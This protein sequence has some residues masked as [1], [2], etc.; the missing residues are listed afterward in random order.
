MRTRTLHQVIVGAS[1]GDAIT[2]QALLVRSWLRDFG[3]NSEIYAE[4]IHEDLAGDIR[5]VASLRLFRGTP[6]LIVHHSIGSNILDELVR[7]DVRLILV[8]HNVTPPEFFEAI[9]PT[10]AYM[11]RRG[12]DQLL[13]LQQRTA[14]ALADS[15]YNERELL[16][17]GF[18]RTG[19]LP[20][21]L[22]ESLYN[23][24]PDVTMLQQL[25]N[26]GPRLLFVGR[27]A[28]NKK[29]EDLIKL[30]YFYRR[31]EPEAQLIL[32]G[33]PWLLGYDRWLVDLANSLGIGSA[34]HLTGRV[35]QP[36]LVTYYHAADL[37]VSMS[38]HE[39]FG[40]PLIESMFLGLPILAYRGTAI[41]YTLG[42]AGVMFR[43]KDFE[44]VAE[45]ADILLKDQELRERI[46]AQ[47]YDRVRYFLEPT[48]RQTLHDVLLSLGLLG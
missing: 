43:E 1:P 41:P 6:W 45:L 40:K 46:I 11:L 7:Q 34:V 48:V 38:E 9:D 44:A 22:D 23:H 42:K 3:F 47:Q 35:S 26:S 30:L 28:P 16:A 14:F 10:W 19:V 15:A 29:Q 33:D 17:Y 31:I 13:C 5:A 39:G 20:I 32:V 36:D 4:H 18:E 8:Y 21:T 37:Y 2:D 27:F 24:P 25:R 12:Q